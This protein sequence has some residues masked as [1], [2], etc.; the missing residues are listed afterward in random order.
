MPPSSRATLIGAIALLLW[1]CQALLTRLTGAVPP[2]QLVAMTFSL[3]ALLALGRWRIRG[4]SPLTRLRQPVGAWALSVTGLFGYHFLYFTALKIAPPVETTL[5][6]YLWPLLIVLFSALLVR[7]EP[8]R[9]RHIA[10]A[11]A[12][13]G[14]AALLVLGSGQN[15]A[16]DPAFALGYASAVACSIIWALYSVLNRR[17]RNVPSD[18]VGGFCGATAILALI[19][20][21]LF[22]SWVW[23]QPGQ[24][25][26]ILALGLGPLGAAFFVWD[27]GCKHGN[28]RALG[29]LAYGGPLVSIGLLILH[30]DG[31][32]TEQV[33]LAALLIIGGAALGAGDLVSWRGL[34]ARWTRPKTHA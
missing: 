34:R 11:L 28:I 33:A 1:S 30:G 13:L 17:Y 24:W 32:L 10:G 19:S 27:Y 23:P 18:A 5:L 8:L 3:A 29:T 15:A 25:V 16:F 2:F 14:G 21:L 12:G 4:E 7:D 22:E 26:A 20:H 31:E 9:P 6:N